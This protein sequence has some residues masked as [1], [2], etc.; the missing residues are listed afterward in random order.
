MQPAFRISMVR[1]RPSLARFVSRSACQ[2]QHEVARTLV[3][4]KA[5]CRVARSRL[6]ILRHIC[7]P[8]RRAL[9]L[10]VCQLDGVCAC[11]ERSGETTRWRIR[12]ERHFPS[13][14]QS[15]ICSLQNQEVSKLIEALKCT[16]RPDMSNAM[17][18]SLV[19]PD[20]SPSYPFVSLMPGRRI[21]CDHHS[22]TMTL[23]LASSAT[24]LLTQTMRAESMSS[25]SDGLPQ[26]I[27]QC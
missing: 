2:G 4:N 8:Q 20:L 3:E 22:C 13:D 7:L 17:L 25:P 23:V 16:A 9:G 14:V 11:T 6:F 19:S 5:V 27:S 10:F 18:C 1:K 26:C 15:A 21:Q 12:L 24:V